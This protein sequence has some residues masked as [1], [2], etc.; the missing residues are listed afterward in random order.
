MLFGASGKP[1]AAHVTTIAEDLRRGLTTDSPE[2][3]KNRAG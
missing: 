2:S 3:L 1:M